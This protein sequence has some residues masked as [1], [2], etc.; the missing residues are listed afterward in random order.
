MRLYLIAFFV[1]LFLRVNGQPSLMWNVGNGS[2]PINLRLTSAGD[3][4]V[5]TTQGI[6]LYSGA[7]G[8]LLRQDFNFSTADAVVDD[9]GSV[10]ITGNVDTL[11]SSAPYIRK[12][13]SVF[14]QQWMTVFFPAGTN[15]F[16]AS[17]ILLSNGNA[18]IAGAFSDSILLATGCYS[19]SVDILGT[20]RWSYGFVSSPVNQDYVLFRMDQLGQPV[21]GSNVDHLDSSSGEMSFRTIDQNGSFL[22]ES[23][24][25]PISARDILTDIEFGPGNLYYLTGSYNL[26]NAIGNSVSVFG[27]FDSNGLLTNFNGYDGYYY[28]EGQQ[29]FADSLIG[30]YAIVTGTDVL[31]TTNSHFDV[32]RL[33]DVGAITWQQRHQQGLP[34]FEYAND[35]A[36]T[37]CKD[38]QVCGRYR[39]TVMLH[40]DGIVVRYDSTGTMQWEIYYRQPGSDV[41]FTKLAIVDDY[42][43]YALG[44]ST[45]SLGNIQLI[46]VKYNQNT[47]EIPTIGSSSNARIYP[48]PTHDRL[49]IKCDGFVTKATVM[50]AYGRNSLVITD[51]VIRSIDVSTLEPGSYYMKIE[52]SNGFIIRRFLKD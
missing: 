51:E 10:Y 17:N 32:L 31:G 38:V 21:I 2:T 52:S 49:Y 34:V 16:T 48:N 1:L 12:V 18:Y 9:A 42:T 6:L 26:T 27:V 36:I 28:D 23:V 13:D 41:E 24:F 14:Q 43:C 7:N 29:L 15:Q 39:N 45:D 30:V 5:V 25:D 44:T 40:D 8:Q 3:V 47:T 22:H 4:L 37:P 19:A 20:I 35:L 11:G 50:D 46:L 33:S